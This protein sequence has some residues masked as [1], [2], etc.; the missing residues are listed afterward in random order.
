MALLESIIDIIVACTS[1]ISIFIAAKALKVSANT[2]KIQMQHNMLS[3]KPVCEIYT[4]NY[5][6]GYLAVEIQ[7]KGMGLMCIDSIIFRD[8]Q[9]I[10]H[11]QLIDCVNE[12]SKLSYLFLEKN[13]VIMAGEK[14]KLVRG[15]HLT[16]NEREK[17]VDELM[18]VRVQIE[19]KDVY[20]NKYFYDDYVKFADCW[21]YY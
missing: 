4:A 7:N 13:K 10:T 9:G 12:K 21:Q 14:L 17:L 8:K 6:D 2:T 16:K 15:D 3:M 1:I 20:F 11:K 18:T 19:Y 5:D